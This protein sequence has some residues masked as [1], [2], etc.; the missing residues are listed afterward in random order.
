MTTITE[1][2]RRHLLVSLGYAPPA[3][4]MPDLE[5]LRATQ[6]CEEFHRLRESRLILGAFRYG[7]LG[8]PNKPQYDNVPDMIRRLN[9]Y[10]ETGNLEYL[11]DVANLC[12]CEWADGKHPKRHY[13]PSDDGQHT[14]EI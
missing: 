1:H 3:K 10:H 4:R 5:T 2:L 6:R 11:L 14:P 12:E 7:F 9:A 13:R 8:D